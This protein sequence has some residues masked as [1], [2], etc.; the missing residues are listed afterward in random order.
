[1]SPSRRWCFVAISSTIWFN[2][3]TSRTS[4]RRYES[5]V[6]SSF[7]A[8]AWIRAKSGEGVSRRSSA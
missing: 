3:G 4:I 2:F 5:E 6:P 7:S 8:R 1:M